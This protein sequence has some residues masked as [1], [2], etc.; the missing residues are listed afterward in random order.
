MTQNFIYL[1]KSWGRVVLGASLLAMIIAGLITPRLPVKWDAAINITMPVP[2]R[3][4][5]G[6]YEYDGY[7]A[8]QAT[9]LFSSNVAGWFK[10]PGFV[11]RVYSSAGIHKKESSLRKLEKM[12]VIKKISGQLLQVSFSTESEASAKNLTGSIKKEIESN[13]AQ[14]NLGGNQQLKFNVLVSEPVIVKN[15]QNIIVNILMTGFVVLVFGINMV[16][17]IDTFTRSEK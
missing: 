2:S 10:T 14:F 4:T 1:L 16:L 11:T 17:I 12:F 6:D 13:V 3:S 5:S 15:S 7:Y 9:D 8:L